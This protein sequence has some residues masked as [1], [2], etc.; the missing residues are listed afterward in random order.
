MLMISSCSTSLVGF[1]PLKS[2][3]ARASWGKPRCQLP[4]AWSCKLVQ[5]LCAMGRAYML[6]ACVVV[7]EACCCVLHDCQDNGPG[8]DVG[9]PLRVM[10]AACMHQSL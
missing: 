1:S 10:L 2:M 5:H 9:A 8:Q 4:A 6:H 7:H 3:L